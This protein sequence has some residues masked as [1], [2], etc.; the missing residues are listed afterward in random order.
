MSDIPLGVKL[1]CNSLFTS[2]SNTVMH[3]DNYNSTACM[4]AASIN[5]IKRTGRGEERGEENGRSVR[6]VFLKLQFFGVFL[7]F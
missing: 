7:L 3:T 4:S 5:P 1:S 2:Y 6:K